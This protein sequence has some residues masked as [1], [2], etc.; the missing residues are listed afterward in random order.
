MSLCI[1]ANKIEQLL[2]HIFM[3]SG[4]KDLEMAS[5]VAEN[6]V[7]AE[8]RNIRSHGLVQTS[9]YSKWM[10]SGRM[11][12]KPQMKIVKETPVTL[13]IDADFAPGAV[14]GKY[15]MNLT[16]AKA[17]ENGI[18]MTTVKNGTHYGISAYYA[19][20]A[21]KEDMIGI[22][23]TNSV[24]LMAPFGGYERELGTNPICIAAPAKKHNAVIYDGATSKAAYN[25]IFFAYTDGREIPSDW[26]LD[27]GGRDTTNPKDI[28]IDKGAVL[29]SGE[30]KG[31]GLAVMVNILTGLLS[32]GSITSNEHGDIEEDSN[33]TAYSFM[34][35][36]ISKFTEIEAFKQTTD[37]FIERLKNSKKRE[38][39]EE[40]F[41]PGEIEDICYEKSKNEGIILGD[42]VA[43][44]ITK[45]LEKLQIKMTLQDCCK[46]N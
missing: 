2:V 44:E 38:N 11:N 35:I 17:K 26:A 13:A 42:G 36:D 12:T 27:P 3:E 41:V 14:A 43:K 15:A 31:Y 22:A 18:A 39:V 40:I 29:P 5:T 24:K 10:L 25:K 7:L 46:R 6:L 32:G 37:L 9:N 28:I 30:Y 33:A 45:T 4:L 16:I 20:Q 19:M 34:V 23:F 8:M 1:D 21:T